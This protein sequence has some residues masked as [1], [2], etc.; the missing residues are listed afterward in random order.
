MR[1]KVM[2]IL[3]LF[4]L[5]LVKQMVYLLPPSLQIGNANTYIAN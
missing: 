3:C 1:K 2:E 4:L 5:K